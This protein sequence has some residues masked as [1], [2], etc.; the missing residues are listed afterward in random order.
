MTFPSGLRALNHRDFRLLYG[1]QLLAQT[2]SWMQSV[3]QSWLVLELTNSPFR[4]GLIGTL[5][6]GP[7]LLF[8][9]VSGVVADRASKRR[10][11]MATQATFAFQA[12]VLAW[13]AATGQVA[14]W[15]V[16]VFALLAGV[17]NVLDGP[18]RQALVM[19]LVGKADVINAVALNSASFNT[20]RI[21]G[22][23]IAG[24]LIARFGVTPAFVLNGVGF[25]GAIAALAVLAEPS[26]PAHRGGATIF[27]EIAEGLRYA[28]RT[29]RI[30]LVLGVLL[31]VSF[32]V[33][34]FTVY[35]PLL[36]RDVLGLGAEGFGFLMTALGIGA[37]A[38]ALTI[39]TS[40]PRH[41]ELPALLTAAAIALAG[42]LGLAAAERFWVAAAI[43][44]VTG[45]S[46][47]VVLAGCNTTLQLGTP[48]GLRGRVMSLYLLAHG[49]MFPIGAFVIGAISERWGVSRAFLVNGVAGLAAL[50]LIVAWWRRRAAAER[51]G[52]P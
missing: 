40:G 3:A 12:L 14:Y 13:L 19:E 7:V 46:G 32:C 49:G 35:V 36:A 10:L 9:I 42:L 28:L 37:V 24:L 38:G 47:T 48:D 27:E 21:V 17:A 33:F 39:G 6:F 52:S 25:L 34:N 50:A 45:F 4:L 31:V 8:S 18:A 41:P 16:A 43:L 22:P 44:A 1:A 20:A 26:L 23:A 29:P 30:R 51:T 11:L 2:G 5:Q 15:H